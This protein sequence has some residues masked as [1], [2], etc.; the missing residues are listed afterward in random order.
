MED[1]TVRVVLQLH[2]DGERPRELEGGG[3]VRLSER[4]P[5][6]HLDAGQAL[7]ILDLIEGLR[8][9]EMA[10]R[11]VV[12]LIIALSSIEPEPVVVLI[13]EVIPICQSIFIVRLCDHAHIFVEFGGQSGRLALAVL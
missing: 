6:L 3:A 5:R 13:F 12:V 9:K 10:D 2:V 1:V 11:P 4:R 7:A 8:V